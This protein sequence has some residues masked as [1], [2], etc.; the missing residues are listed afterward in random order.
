M[1]ITVPFI[2]SFTHTLGPLELEVMRVVW[3]H[4]APVTVR[5]V[6]RAINTK[7]PFEEQLAYTTVM[8]AMHRLTEADKEML[9][10][11]EERAHGRA[12]LFVAAIDR[13]TF[14]GTRK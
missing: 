12:S 5:K 8:T 13:A 11:L 10:E 14:L 3:T 9:T 7:R 6:E 4:N 2:P 1:E